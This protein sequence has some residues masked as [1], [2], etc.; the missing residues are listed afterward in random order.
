[1]GDNI[2]CIEIKKPVSKTDVDKRGKQAV[3]QGIAHSYTIEEKDDHWLL[4]LKL[5][6]IE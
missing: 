2:R 4:C 6:V 1:M 3:N 5:V